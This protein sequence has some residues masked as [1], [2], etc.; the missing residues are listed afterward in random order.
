MYVL[1]HRVLTYSSI[2]K[3]I[4]KL[5]ITKKKKHKPIGTVVNLTGK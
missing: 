5:I 2:A 3:M 1:I 4:E